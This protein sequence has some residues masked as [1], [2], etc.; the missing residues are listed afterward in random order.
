MIKVFLGGTC[1]GSLWREKLIS[2]LNDSVEYYNPVVPEWNEE[3]RKREIQAREES[4]FTLYVISPEMTGVYSI[5][6]ATADVFLKNGNTIFAVLF[7]AVAPY[8]VHSGVAITQPRLKFNEKTY[9]SLYQTSKFLEMLGGIV[10]Y[11]LYDVAEFLNRKAGE[12]C[13][14][15]G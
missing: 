12:Q 15:D 1:N 11:S 3:C 6:E 5:A 14:T 13:G 7:E 4:D 8:D 9:Y 10:F 2:M